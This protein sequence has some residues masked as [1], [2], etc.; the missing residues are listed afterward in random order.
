MDAVPG[1]INPGSYHKA[2]TKQKQPGGDVDEKNGSKQELIRTGKNL[3]A[4]GKI[5]EARQIFSE[6][7][8]QPDRSHW[9]GYYLATCLN[10]GGELDES[11]KISREIYKANPEFRQI[12]GTYLYALYKSEI[13]PEK[14]NPAPDFSRLERSIRE[15]L[16][17]SDSKP[18]EFFRGKALLCLASIYIRVGNE[19]EAVMYLDKIDP[20]NLSKERFKFTSAASKDVYLQSDFEKY[21]GFRAKVY[22]KTGEWAKC[23]S[24]CEEAIK[25]GVDDIWIRRRIA[26]AE[27]KLGNRDAGLKSLFRLANARK[28]WFIYIDIAEIYGMKEEYDTALS[29]AAKAFVVGQYGGHIEF[30]TRG[31]SLAAGWCKLLEEKD[32][33]RLHTEYEWQLCKSKEIEISEDLKNRLTEYSISEDKQELNGELNKKLMKFW[34]AKAGFSDGFIPGKISNLMPDKKYGFIKGEDGIDYF[35][36]FSEYKGNHKIMKKGLPVKF[37]GKRGYSEIKQRE[38]SEALKIREVSTSKEHPGGK[39][40]GEL[41]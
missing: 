2:N 32:A 23:K 1:H 3:L 10:K 25:N 41:S 7:W 38:I 35:F 31:L 36:L 21:Y 17:I 27:V 11:L 34:S 20:A 28:N 24:A 6:L 15:V 22:E 14:N 16:D 8:N 26:C 5:Q 29:Y 37:I 39:N 12:I 4:E 9:D 13:E 19:R 18:D 40:E 30:I 33:A